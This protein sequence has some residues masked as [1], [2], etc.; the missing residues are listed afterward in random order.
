[1]NAVEGGDFILDQPEEIPAIWGK[2]TSVL[3]AEGEALLIVGSPGVGKSTLMQQLAIRRLGEITRSDDHHLGLPVEPDYSRR[4]LYIAADRPRQIARSFRRM[5][6]ERHRE[7]L[8][9]SLTFWP[10]PLPFNV[11][12]EPERMLAFAQHHGAGTVVIDGLG[13][14]ASPLSDDMVGGRIKAMFAH[15]VAENVEVVAAYHPRKTTSDGRKPRHLDDVYGSTWITAGVGSVLFLY[16]EAG[17]P[18]VEGLHLKQPA[19]VVGPLEI[20]HDHDHGATV[21]ADEVTAYDLVRSATNGGTTAKD[22]AQRIFR[23]SDPDRNQVERARRK[24]ERLV[25]DGHACKLPPTG[26]NEPVTY[27]PVDR[28][29][30]DAEVVAGATSVR[31]REG[32]VRASR[33]PHDPSR[34]GS[35]TGHATL[36]HSDTAGPP[37]R[38]DP[39]RDAEREATEDEEQRAADLEAR[40]GEAIR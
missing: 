25:E 6:D 30:N 32:R 5:V 24:L 20:V 38:G 31:V 18:I 36:T 35:S 21:A 7:R 37:Y 39:P 40:Y 33:D 28:R 9:R 3:W 8:N 19:D 17:D 34:F 27:R 1:V 15:L 16:G 13:D 4:V 29:H 22:V 2:G 10:G 26:P 23:T 12:Q 14:I 11:V